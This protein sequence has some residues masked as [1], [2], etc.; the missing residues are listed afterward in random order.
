MVE[1]F[2]AGKLTESH[3]QIQNDANYQTSLNSQLGYNS[4][5]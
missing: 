1:G 2:S 4:T 3:G 5:K